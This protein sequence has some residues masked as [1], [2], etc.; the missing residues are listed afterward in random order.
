[1]SGLVDRAN[2]I[3]I[4]LGDLKR[5]EADADLGKALVET[6]AKVARLISQLQGAVEINRLLSEDGLKIPRL[7]KNTVE[8]ARK[9]KTNARKSATNLEKPDQ[10]PQEIVGILNGKGVQDGA[11]GEGET[12]A[13]AL[14]QGVETA[15]DGERQA[16][17]P[18]NIQDQI[19]DGVP[20]T[21]KLHRA[22]R[23]AREFLV[24]A[25]RVTPTDL[26]AG[27][28]S[29]RDARTARQSAVEAWETNHSDLVELI[30]KEDPEIQKFFREASSPDG[31][32]LIRLTDKVLER[33]KKDDL[34]DS[35]R[36]HFR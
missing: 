11:L 9:A 20:H 24:T 3:E 12:I 19:P 31:A 36:I 21:F 29:I 4:A 17:L 14:A 32:S 5:N 15:L 28:E 22:L 34:T 2:E 30:E 7:A 33:L 8:S 27:P 6:S 26:A 35:Y 25:V 18:K 1:M 10:R 16:L 23:K 13:K